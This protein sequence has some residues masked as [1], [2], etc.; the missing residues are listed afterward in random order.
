MLRFFF[1]LTSFRPPV[2][3]KKKGNSAFS[4]FLAAATKR[5]VTEERKGGKKNSCRSSLYIFIY[6][7]LDSNGKALFF[8]IKFINPSLPS[9]ADLSVGVCMYVM[10]AVFFHVCL[11]FFFFGV[12][13]SSCTMEKV[14]FAKHLWF[15]S[16]PFFIT[17]FFYFMKRGSFLF[18]P[19]PLFCSYCCCSAFFM[20]CELSVVI[21]KRR[22]RKSSLRSK[23]CR[24]L[25]APFLFLLSFSYLLF[26]LFSLFSGRGNCA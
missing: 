16:P 26:G 6:F 14:K 25:T 21:Q 22:K 5:C 11:S 18:F 15:S 2:T 17:V 9:S 12:F 13:F 8:L 1:H 4:S 24:Y 10:H 19:L 7:L 20:I 23:I 3:L